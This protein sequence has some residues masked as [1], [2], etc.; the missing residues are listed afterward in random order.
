V[1]EA[2][3]V[4]ALPYRAPTHYHHVTKRWSRLNQVFILEHSE[5]MLTACKI[6]TK[7]RGVNTDH[8]PIVTKLS[9]GV[10][11]QNQEPVPNFREVN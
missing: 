4:M 10:T 1:A 7:H 3:L 9:L 2:G 6:L 8:L 5:D 11:L